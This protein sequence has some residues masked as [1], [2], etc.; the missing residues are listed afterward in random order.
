MVLRYPNGKTYQPMPQKK[1]RNNK[2][3]N[4]IFGNRG[5][6]LEEEI[7]QSN[8]YYLQQGIAVIHKKPIPIQ[9]VQV[10]YPQRSAAVI[11]EAYFKQASTTDYNGVYRGYYLDFEAKETHNKASFPLSNFHEHQIAHMKACV[12]QKGICF[13]LIKFTA[14]QEVFLLPASILFDYWDNQEK[15]RKSIPKKT[16]VNDGFQ[17]K[18]HVTPLIPYLK[19]IDKVIENL[20]NA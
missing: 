15:G 4:I 3:S 9:I 12:V 8:Q 19:S 11:K 16:I 5:M 17:I 1:I 2:N 7:N 14:T 18:Y 6:S 10:D 13:T 20:C